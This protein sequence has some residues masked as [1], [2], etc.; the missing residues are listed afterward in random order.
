MLT[1]QKHLFSLPESVHYL[2]CASMSPLL[3]SVEEAG[4]HG[5]QRKSRPHE[6]HQE[7]FF[8]TAETV[9]SLFAQLIH[10]PDTQRIAI[11]PSV[12]YG[13]AIVAKN[14]LKRKD[15]RAG[16][17]I[18]VVGEEFPSDVYAWEEVCTEQQLHLQFVPAP[19]T[20]QNRGQAWNAELL[21]AIDNQTVLLCIS[22]I[23]WADGTWFD[24][25]SLSQKCQQTGTWLGID[26]TQCIGAY[27]F[28]IQELQPTFVVTG[29][30]KW[31]L[32]PYSNALAYFS[33]VFDNGS[34][35]ERNWVTRKDSD[36]FKS[37]VHYQTE[38][39]PKA[40]RYTM[41]EMSNF[42]QLPMIATALTQ[43]LAWTPEAIQHYCENL[44]SCILPDIQQAG[45]WIEEETFRSSHLFG[46]RAVKEVNFLHLQQ[47]LQQK[48]IYVSFRGNCIRISPHVYND[49]ADMQALAEVLVSS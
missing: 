17:K 10:C 42:I 9:K 49:A 33:D 11:L 47:T 48:N 24:L 44:V 45:F 32:G 12:S 29:A 14:L 34:P 26:G 28:D 43:I 22:P 15:L 46:L 19:D 3:K 13:M 4:I 37:L 35:L 39:R 18:V 20:L 36:D 16:Q 2:N 38:F 25:T 30:Y 6:I 21:H 5:L 31:L 8:D 7:H 23:H 41:G 27:S 40:Y 1:C